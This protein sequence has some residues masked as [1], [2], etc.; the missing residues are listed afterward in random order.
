MTYHDN[1]PGRGVGSQ[2]D[3]VQGVGEETEHE[4][5]AVIQIRRVLRPPRPGKQTFGQ[6]NQ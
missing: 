3:G 1:V 5:P 2:S 4:L 6:K